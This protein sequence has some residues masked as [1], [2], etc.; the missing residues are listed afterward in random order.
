[1]VSSSNTAS[2]GGLIGTYS[3]EYVIFKDTVEYCYS[4][5]TESL[6]GSGSNS[7]VISSNCVSYN[8]NP[9]AMKE[10]SSFAEFDFTNIWIIG[11]NDYPYPSLRNNLRVVISDAEEI[12]LNVLIYRAD[13]I[14]SGTYDIGHGQYSEYAF[15]NEYGSSTGLI[16]ELGWGTATLAA[17]WETL[18]KL[19]EAVETGG[20]SLITDTLEEKDVYGAI[21]LEAL[22]CESNLRYV[23]NFSD[24]KLIKYTNDIT[25]KVGDVII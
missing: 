12:D 2:A 3:Y 14:T 13:S 15:T 4:I 1:M 22:E 6:I 23:K 9:D 11:D 18:T 5:N 10:Q 25:K 19:V 17:A 16:N 21:L 8:N 20:L 24:N 7:Q